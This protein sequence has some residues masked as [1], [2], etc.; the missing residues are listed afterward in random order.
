MKVLQENQENPQLVHKPKYYN[1]WCTHP[2]SENKWQHKRILRHVVEFKKSPVH[3]INQ[4][5]KEAHECVKAWV[6][7]C[8][9][10]CT[11]LF[12]I[13]FTPSTKS[14]KEANET[15]TWQNRKKWQ[16]NFLR[17]NIRKCPPYEKAQSTNIRCQDFF[18]VI[19][20]FIFTRKVGPVRDNFLYFHHCRAPK[21]WWKVMG[22]RCVSK[23]SIMMG[24]TLALQTH[25]RRLWQVFSSA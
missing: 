25:L 19:K 2:R 22:L 13:L 14:I 21:R 24:L 12:R 15:E 7:R 1:V 10:K 4:S 9:L 6:R 5:K 23:V 8:N 16:T 18:S 17:W 3:N 11:K 20:F